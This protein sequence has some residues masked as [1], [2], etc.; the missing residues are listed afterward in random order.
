M[1]EDKDIAD[2]VDPNKEPRYYIKRFLTESDYKSWFK[3]N[4]PE[5]TIYEAVGISKSEF[6]KIKRKLDKVVNNDGKNIIKRTNELGKAGWI[7]SKKNGETISLNPLYK[8]MI[9]NYINEHLDLG[10]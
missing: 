6:D 8:L 1:S 7:F 4:Y 2:F 3:K 9:R 5:Y 10:L